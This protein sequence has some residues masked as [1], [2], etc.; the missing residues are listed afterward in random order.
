[1]LLLFVFVCLLFFL[2]V[3]FF[4]C[5]FLAIY[6]LGDSDVLCGETACLEAEITLEQDVYLPISWDRVEG[7]S[8]KQLD[9]ASDKYRWSNS[10]QLLI[11]SVC[12]DDEAGYQ[13]VISR[14]QDVKI[15][16]NE[17][18]LRALGGISFIT[19][20]IKYLVFFF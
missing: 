19:L 6:I 10:R 15:F 20:F 16:S 18:Y 2:L 5:V 14:N 7:L 3:F 13:A 4:L 9:I 12:K 1:M 11:H 17:I 8:R